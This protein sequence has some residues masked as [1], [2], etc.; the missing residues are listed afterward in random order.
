MQQAPL[1]LSALPDEA[2]EERDGHPTCGTRREQIDEPAVARQ[3]DARP[4]AVH[5]V[6]FDALRSKRGQDCVIGLWS[7]TKAKDVPRSRAREVRRSVRARARHE[8]RCAS[9]L[10]EVEL[11]T[12]SGRR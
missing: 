7:Q 1:G 3:R 12:E 9:T 4:L 5:V 6:R 8:R 10:L 11:S 2:Q